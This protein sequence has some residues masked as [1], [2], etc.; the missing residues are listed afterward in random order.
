MLNLI[1]L[2]AAAVS[3]S[4]HLAV[5]LRS[6]DVCRRPTL[7]DRG[8][9]W[10]VG[11]TG[12][13]SAGVGSLA[14][15]DIAWPFSILAVAV[16]LEWRP[17]PRRVILASGDAWLALGSKYTGLALSPFWSWP[18]WQIR[19]LAR[20]TSD[21]T[22]ILVG[23]AADR[24]SLVRQ[25]PDLGRQPS[26][27]VRLGGQAGRE[28]LRMLMAYLQS[29]GTS[30]CWPTTYA[31]NHALPSVGV[32]GPSESDRHPQPFLDRA[33]FLRKDH[34][35]RPLGGSCCCD[36]F[37]GCRDVDVPASLHV[38]ALLSTAVIEAWI[39]HPGA[40]R[41]HRWRQRGSWLG[42]CGRWPTR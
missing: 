20:V 15:A 16:Y 38:L 24:G 35:F 41:W 39:A 5:A 26:L 9:G 18:W 31:P 7:E 12:I 4:R 25:E 30:R 27:P 29:F 40:P 1:G 34:P 28:R 3:W 17:P 8:A 10:R 11:L 22:G 32:P 21:S 2:A 6:G 42:Y 14:S 36:S 37:M 33:L 23:G 13:P 19:G